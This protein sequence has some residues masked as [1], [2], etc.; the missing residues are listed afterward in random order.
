MSFPESAL[1]ATNN[2]FQQVNSQGCFFFTI[3]SSLTLLNTLISPWLPTVPQ[4]F[5]GS[6]RLLGEGCWDNGGCHT[7]WRR[8]KTMGQNHIQWLSKHSVSDHGSGTV[9]EYLTAV[10]SV[11]SPAC[12][13]VCAHLCFCWPLLSSVDLQWRLGYFSFLLC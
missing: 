7:F 12:L 10:F 13:F 1:T 6:V 11:H 2:S 8:W 9:C 5:M 4:S 3:W